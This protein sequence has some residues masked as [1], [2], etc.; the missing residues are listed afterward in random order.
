MA[1]RLKTIEDMCK[2][3]FTICPTLVDSAIQQPTRKNQNDSENSML[4][5]IRDARTNRARS[6]ARAQ[7][8]HDKA[9]FLHI[10]RNGEFL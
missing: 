7:G 3:P 9:D 8:R 2:A 4:C 5:K 6:A 10:A 1:T